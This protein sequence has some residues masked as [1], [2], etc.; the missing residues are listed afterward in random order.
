MRVGVCGVR[1]IVRAIVGP[2]GCVGEVL[3]TIRCGVGAPA[4]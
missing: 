4:V 2:V 3:K 1:A